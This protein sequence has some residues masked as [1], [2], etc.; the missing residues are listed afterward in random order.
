MINPAYS[1]DY[2]ERELRIKLESVRDKYPRELFSAMSYYVF[3]SGKRVRPRLVFLAADLF[4]V[5]YCDVVNQAIA[6][7]LI[8]NYSLIHDD[9][10]CM[11]NDDY[12]RGKPTC[13]KK[14]GEAMAVLAGDALLNLAYEIL[15]DT[16]VRKP[17]TSLSCK[18]VSDYAGSDGMVVGQAI[19]F[20]IDK[21]SQ[22]EWELV[23]CYRKKTGGLI[24]ASLIV[25][26]AVKNDRSN[27]ELMSN[28]GDSLGMIFQLTDD[29]L[30]GDKDN[31]SF[32][33]LYGEEKT[34]KVIFDELSLIK[35]VLS[36]FQEKGLPLI[37]F[38]ELIVARK[39]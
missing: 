18:S 21:V 19:E 38:C 6:I 17:F 15:F 20:C 5:E 22:C 16:A 24:K 3:N 27:M 11:D 28:V 10:P 31:L 32:V 9:L 36:S 25:A 2:F 37:K 23:D 14:Y 13:H 7:E 35:T 34:K 29:I 12:R 39:K 30:D 8:H 4:C 1:M 33:K 26:P